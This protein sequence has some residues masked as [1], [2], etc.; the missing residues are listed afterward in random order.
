M[1]RIWTS[2]NTGNAKEAIRESEEKYRAFFATS[3]DVVFITSREGR[4]VD[5]NDEA[6]AFFGFND[7]E[8]FGTVRVQD[9]YSNPIGREGHI[10]AIE[11]SGFVKDYPVALRK[12]DGSII[13]ALVTSIARKDLSGNVLGFQGTIKD[14]TEQKQAEEALRE[15]E[16]K[17]RDLF[18]NSRDGIVFADIKTHKF[19]DSN[20]MFSLMLGYNPDEIKTLNITDIHPEDCLSYILDVFEKMMKHKITIVENIPVKRKDGTIFYADISAYPVNISGKGYLAGV[21]RDITERMKAEEAL[22]ES[23]AIFKTVMDSLDALVYVADMKTYE[24][25]FVNQYGREIWGDL[26]GK[27]LLG[28]TSGR[29]ERSL[30]ILHQ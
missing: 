29:S 11:E 20:R 10:R 19:V 27:N 21:F 28:I 15:S 1:V 17:F 9:L 6:P 12:K 5:F 4:F 13:S 26:T 22:T 7:R 23:F 25:L 2:P 24:V 18:E 30:P 16:Q 14:I 3:K 8:E